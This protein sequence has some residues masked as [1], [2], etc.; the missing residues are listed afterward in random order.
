MER[1]EFVE[2]AAHIVRRAM[3]FSDKARREGLLALDDEIDVDGL[4]RRDIFELGIRLV[5]DGTDFKCIDKILSN[6]LDLERDE[7]TKGLK[8][9]QKEAALLIQ[10]GMNTRLLLYT[11]FSYLGNDEMD[12]VLGLLNDPDISQEFAINEILSASEN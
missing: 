5:V 4:R 11:L 10:D 12:E 9:I 3:A 6:M 1:K 8:T 7:L 2:Q